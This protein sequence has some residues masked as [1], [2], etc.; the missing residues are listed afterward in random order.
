[1]KI[2]IRVLAVLT[3]VILVLSCASTSSISIKVLKPA[4][5]SMPG[6]H[7]IAVIDFH[8]E[9]RSG[10]QIA[11]LLQSMLL[12]TGYYEILEREKI[13]RILEEKNMALSGIVDDQTAV[14]VGSLLGVRGLI[15][16]LKLP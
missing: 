16:K 2:G 6:V 5:I 12:E 4:A 1:M 14:Q 11:T 9:G 13:N 3:A 10:S 8:G 7:K 15:T